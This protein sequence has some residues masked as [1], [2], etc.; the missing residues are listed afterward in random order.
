MPMTDL[1]W[2]YMSGFVEGQ[3]M[4]TAMLAA[5]L[6]ESGVLPKGRV[7]AAASA[8]VQA[9]KDDDPRAVVMQR[10]LRAVAEGAPLETRPRHPSRGPRRTP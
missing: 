6:I 3:T 5:L 9:L 1:D 2:E 8:L 10:F 4:A 7:I